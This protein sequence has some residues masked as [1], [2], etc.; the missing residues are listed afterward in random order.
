MASISSTD[1]FHFVNNQIILKEIISKQS[2]W[3]FYCIE[4]CWNHRHWA[5]PM[6]CFCDIPLSQVR[7]HIRKYGGNGYGIGMK[8]KWAIDKG[9]T[10]VLYTSYKCDIYKKVYKVSKTLIPSV[11]EKDL[12]MEERLLYRIKRIK[13]SEYE[14]YL[15]NT[16]NNKRIKFYN[17]R[18][19]R[20]VPK[21]TKDVHMVPWD[22]QKYP[23]R[24]EFRIKL[25]E[26]TKDDR[27][28]FNTNDI[29]FIIV[30]KDDDCKEMINFLRSLKNISESKIDLMISKIITTEE[31]YNNF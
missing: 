15:N 29:A 2:F 13:A 17:E 4:Y 30:P 12:S 11:A 16:K 20:Y 7:I 22:S 3:P 25:S 1:L 10:P 8:K 27:L 26:N 19:W 24:N 5:I 6:L 14:Q 21:V 18:E 9:I 28:K 31:I 23:D